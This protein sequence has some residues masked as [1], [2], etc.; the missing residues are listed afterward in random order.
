MQANDATV[1]TCRRGTTEGTHGVLRLA[2]GEDGR[3]VAREAHKD[4]TAPDAQGTTIFMSE[5]PAD[6]VTTPGDVGGMWYGTS[7]VARGACDFKVTTTR[8]EE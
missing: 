1:Y 7:H 6:D 3:W 5:N 4:I 8:V 2:L